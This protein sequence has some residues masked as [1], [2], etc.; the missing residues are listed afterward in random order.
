ME[1]TRLDLEMGLARRVMQGL[2]PPSPPK[3]VGFDIATFHQ[4]SR[5]VS[6]DYYDF[7]PLGHGRWGLVVADVVG[8]GIAAALLVTALQAS[9]TSLAGLELALRAI[10]RRAN[11]FLRGSAEQARDI[12]SF[13]ATM[14][15]AVLDVPS[16]RLIYVNAGHL[17]VLL[18]R[19]DGGIEHLAEGGVPLGF[20]DDPSYHE[21]FAALRPGD[22][23]VAYTDGITEAEDA[24]GRFYGIDRLTDVVRNARH[25]TAAEVRDAVAR[26]VGAHSPGP[27]ADDETIVVI[28]AVPR[29]DGS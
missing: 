23:L 12:S 2:L 17:P 25:G 13:Y 26:D 21:G 19:A 22:M 1:K 9:L 18:V 7:I 29:G 28:K 5:E 24:D 27:I 8:K 15:Y 20:F 16:R 6:G 4:W 3:L 14:F 10:F 11:R